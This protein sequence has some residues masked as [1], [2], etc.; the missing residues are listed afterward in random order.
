MVEEEVSERLEEI[1]IEK[2][3]SISREDLLK[4]RRSNSEGLSLRNIE[5]LREIILPKQKF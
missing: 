4:Y 3:D 2:R 1:L 5:S